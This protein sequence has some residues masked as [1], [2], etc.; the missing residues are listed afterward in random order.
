M[1]RHH[2]GVKAALREHGFLALA[3]QKR[4]PDKDQYQVYALHNFLKAAYPQPAA[5]PGQDLSKNAI[6]QILNGTGRRPR[7]RCSAPS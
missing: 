5:T 3:L 7:R 2:S 4:H 6:E 1:L